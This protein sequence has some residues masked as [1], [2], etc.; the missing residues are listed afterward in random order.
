MKQSRD[1]KESQRKKRLESAKNRILAPPQRNPVDS[2]PVSPPDDL[3]TRIST[4]AYT[5]YT[6][7]G[8]RQGFAIEDWLD[9]EREI[10]NF[11]AKS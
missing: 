11:K 8:Y 9:A 3:Q 4:R 7:R 6:E 2:Q 10:L 5:L 1:E